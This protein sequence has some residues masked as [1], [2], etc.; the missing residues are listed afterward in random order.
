M[1]PWPTVKLLLGGGAEGGVVGGRAGSVV[2]S[3]AVGRGG[4][5]GRGVDVG[6]GLSNADY[7]ETFYGKFERSV[8]LPQGVE[9]DKISA[10]YQHGALEVRVPLPAQLAGRKI[11]IQIQD[12][13]QKKLD[14]KAA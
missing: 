11:P 5:V 6:S 1:E 3:A 9:A 7:Q 8:S 10:Q 4:V 12:K 2:G 13:G 14:S